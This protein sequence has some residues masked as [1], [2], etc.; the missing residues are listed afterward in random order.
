METALQ[1]CAGTSGLT[2]IDVVALFTKNYGGGAADGFPVVLFLQATQKLLSSSVKLGEDFH[3]CHQQNWF[4]KQN[5][6]FSHD[7]NIFDTLQL[8]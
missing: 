5:I 6:N 4:Q 1:I 3:D 7:Q 2:Y 8:Q